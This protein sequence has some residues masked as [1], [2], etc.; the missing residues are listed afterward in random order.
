MR[1]LIISE[2]PVV[3]SFDKLR[4]QPPANRCE[5][6]G[7]ELDFYIIE[8][9]QILQNKIRAGVFEFAAWR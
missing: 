6:F 7:F 3:S 9:R 8:L 2:I 5:S 4:T 1:T